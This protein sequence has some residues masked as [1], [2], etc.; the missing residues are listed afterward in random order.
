MKQHNFINDSDANGNERIIIAHAKKRRFDIVAWLVCLALAFVCWIYFANM[1]DDD[2]TTEIKVVLDVVGEESLKIEKGQMIYGLD[3]QE[4]TLVIKG[5]NRDIKKYSSS[6]YKVTVDVSKISGTGKHVLDL[7]T[8]IPG[9]S[10]VNLSV[11]SM[12]PQ[13]VIIYSDQIYTTE[14]P[15][16][17][18]N[19]GINTPYTLGTITQS[20]N[21]VQVTGPR[22]IIESIS[23]AQFRI[24]G[25][26]AFHTST[27]YTGFKLDFCDINGEYMPYDNTLITYSTSDIK[28][29][30]PI[31]TQ[32]SVGVT[33]LAGGDEIDSTRY[34]VVVDTTRTSVIG[35]PTVILSDDIKN[36]RIQ[37]SL[38][39]EEL[40]TGG[41]ITKTVKNSDLPEGIIFDG[42]DSVTFNITVDPIS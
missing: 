15:F 13:N 24:S 16:E 19:A 31:Y 9:D 14:V 11:E 7:K 34:N 5:T 23:R 10:N 38:T 39:A 33:V 37:I 8:V 27:T 22:S 36:Y 3:T 35:D 21:K 40:A 32:K 28:V 6:D 18:V 25:V 12:S 4:V 42:K 2:V 17:V 41:V 20:A 26:T 30:V 1:N 29:T